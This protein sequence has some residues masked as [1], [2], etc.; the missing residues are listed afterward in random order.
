M[1]RIARTI[2][3]PMIALALAGC[4]NGEPKTTGDLDKYG[5]WTCDDLGQY[6][7]DG[8]PENERGERLGEVVSWAKQSKHKDIQHAGRNL[9]NL[10]DLPG[11]EAGTDLL[12]ATCLE[13]EWEAS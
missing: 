4:G 6:L 8:S 1:R 11:W 10:I 2:A 9:E 7:Y 5:Q 13:H 3:L 12:A